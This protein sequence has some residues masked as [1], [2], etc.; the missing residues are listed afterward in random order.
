MKLNWLWKLTGIDTTPIVRFGGAQLVQT[1]EGRLEL[2]G[3]TAED[4]QRIREWISMFWHE[5]NPVARK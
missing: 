1:L 4:R 2:A 3:G 5:A